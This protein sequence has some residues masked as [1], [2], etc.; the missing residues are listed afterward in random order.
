M[1]QSSEVKPDPPP[2]IGEGK[3]LAVSVRCADVGGCKDGTIV[4]QA[5]FSIRDSGSAYALIAEI[6][7]R[8]EWNG[9]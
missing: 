4:L 7:T 6:D 2:L 5:S 8:G 1:E 3:L 9:S